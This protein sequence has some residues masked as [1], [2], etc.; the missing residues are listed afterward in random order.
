MAAVPVTVVPGV[1]DVPVLVTTVP[2]VAL[3]TGVVV[4][5]LPGVVGAAVTDD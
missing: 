2:L 3:V 5:V 4:P 1:V